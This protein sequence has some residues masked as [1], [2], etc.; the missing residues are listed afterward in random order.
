VQD[1]RLRG[2]LGFSIGSL[3]SCELLLLEVAQ[4]QGRFRPARFVG[5]VATGGAD[6][7]EFCKLAALRA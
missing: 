6:E 1:R 2:Q 5:V 7:A 4:Q 3:L